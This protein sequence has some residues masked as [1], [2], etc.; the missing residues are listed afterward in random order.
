ML[1]NEKIFSALE[2]IH[3]S[4][5]SALQRAGQSLGLSPLQAQIIFFV[6]LRGEANVSQLAEQLC[7]SKPTISDSVA[8]LLSKK[9]IKK[10]LGKE[11]ARGYRAVLTTKGRS[12]AALLANYATP[13]QDSINAL[14][15]SQKQALWDALLHLLQ[16]MGVQGLI[17]YQ[18]MCLSC[19]HL[20]RNVGSDAY[21]CRLMEKPLPSEAL[22]IDCD[23]HELVF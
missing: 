17:P 12:E 13:F 10:I 9:L 20:A 11:D 21:Y 2:R 18:R 14:T 3:T 1:L 5:K 4:S 8:A 15:E 19:Q 22:R 23:E 16:T 7:V 6:L